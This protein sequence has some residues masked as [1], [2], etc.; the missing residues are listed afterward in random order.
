MAAQ[1]ERGARKHVNPELD[2]ARLQIIAMLK[3]VTKKKGAEEVFD[4]ILR[5]LKLEEER[6]ENMLI[7][8]FV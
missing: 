8:N 5:P 6:R 1:W 2:A 3:Q 4:Q 7:W